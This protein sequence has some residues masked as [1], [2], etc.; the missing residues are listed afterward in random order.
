MLM[1]DSD[2]DRAWREFADDDA[3][4]RAPARLRP[5]V[6]DAWHAAHGAQPPRNPT[7]YVQWHPRSLVATLAAVAAVIVVVSVS[8]RETGRRPDSRA[9]DRTSTGT[10]AAG[11]SVPGQT[12][13]AVRSAPVDAFRLIADPMFENESSALVRLRL[14]RTSL[15]AM[16]IALIGPDVASLVDVDVVVG[17][18]GLPR[19]IRNLRPVVGLQ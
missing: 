7:R 3:E 2:F 6:M 17:G 10:E 5:A 18:D 13:E 19:A 14:P 16:G 15:E 9:P 8:L 4:T 1:N 12:A 11:T